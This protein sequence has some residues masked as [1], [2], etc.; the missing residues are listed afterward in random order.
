MKGV[1]MEYR[2]FVCVV[3]NCLNLKLEGGTKA[4]RYTAMKNNGTEKQGVMIEN[5]K[6]NIAPTIYLEDFYERFCNGVAMEKIIKE[7]LAFYE[8]VKCRNSWDVSNITCYEKIRNKIVFKL[9]HTQKNQDLLENIPHVK[10]LDLSIVFYALLD[11]NDAG[12][13]TM[14]I[15]NKNMQDWGIGREKLCTDAKENAVK[16]LPAQMLP[17]G[18]VVKELL[19]GEKKCE[20]NLL[21][22]KMVWENNM[23]FMYVLTNS[24]RSFGAACMAYPNVLAQIGA[25]VGENYYILPSSVHEVMIVPQS[26]SVEPKELNEMICEI[27]ETQVEEEEVLGNHAYYYEKDT[28]RLS[29]EE[30][31]DKDTLSV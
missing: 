15:R 2:E 19:Q 9:I 8:K 28:G 22:K 20:E 27:N 1:C 21:E 3:E 26:K 4:S 13:V 6:I 14:L 11:V 18:G 24:I 16:L 29:M 7:I 30:Y 17:I 31:V 23:D 10:L 5:P 12:T 25:L